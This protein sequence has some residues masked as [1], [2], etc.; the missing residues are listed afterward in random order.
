[1]LV[2][3]YRLGVCDGHALV[4]YDIHAFNQ[5][6]DLQKDTKAINSIVKTLIQ[7]KPSINSSYTLSFFKVPNI[8]HTVKA[9]SYNV[10]IINTQTLYILQENKTYS[11]LTI[12]I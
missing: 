12:H 9:S 11:K 7:N 10:T 1:M 2:L 4:T 5:L 6:I 3:A 8:H